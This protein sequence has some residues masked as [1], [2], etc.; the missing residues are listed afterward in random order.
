MGVFSKITENQFIFL[1]NHD[2]RY[3][4][5][6]KFLPTRAQTLVQHPGQTIGPR[7]IKIGMHLP[8]GTSYGHF[9]ENSKKSNYFSQKSRFS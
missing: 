6:R 8:E 5:L 3:L 1:K 7:P 2:F 9:F 4:G